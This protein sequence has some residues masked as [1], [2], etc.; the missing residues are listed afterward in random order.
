MKP[1][2]KTSGPLLNERGRQW[3]AVLLTALAALALAFL[4]SAEPAPAQAASGRAASDSPQG[5][6]K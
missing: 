1:P 6:T 2:F 5:L 3:L 4:C